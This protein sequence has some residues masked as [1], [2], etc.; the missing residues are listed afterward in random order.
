MMAVITAGTAGTINAT[1][2][3]GQLFQ[4]VHWINSVEALAG[5]DSNKF[6]LSKGDNGL[7]DSGFTLDGQ[8]TYNSVTGI[9]TESPMPY[10]SSA[11]FLPGTILG[12]IKGASFSE[13]FI[14]ACLYALVWQRNI[15]KNTQRVIGVNLD[16]NYETSVF[17]GKLSLPYTSTIDTGGVISESAIEWLLT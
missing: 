2:I 15:A 12:T 6:S 5:G 16:F 1:T 13:Y 4:L 17:S 10:L 14:N 7:L 8:L 11:I 9:F 3:E